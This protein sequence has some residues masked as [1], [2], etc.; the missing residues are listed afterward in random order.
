MSSTNNFY[1]I[2]E[3]QFVLGLK[4]E[5]ND[6]STQTW[7]GVPSAVRVAPISGLTK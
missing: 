1:K 2:D 3:I 6:I 5:M 4:L 7:S